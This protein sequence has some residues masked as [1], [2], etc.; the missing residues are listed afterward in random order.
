M[1]P[2]TTISLAADAVVGAEVVTATGVTVEAAIAP[3]DAP[4]HVPVAEVQEGTA[5]L[6]PQS[7]QMVTIAAIPKVPLETGHGSGNHTID[8]SS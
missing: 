3:G 5:D 4:E 6:R 1:L 2:V 8:R 7:E